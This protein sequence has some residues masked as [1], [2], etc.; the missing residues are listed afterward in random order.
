M[1]NVKELSLTEVVI[2]MSNPR[3]KMDAGKLKDLAESIK[4]QGVIE[5]IVVRDVVFTL[6]EKVKGKGL[7]A[8]V[9]EMSDMK[10]RKYEVVCGARRVEAAKLAGLKEIPAVIMDLDDAQVHEMRLIENLQ[11]EDMNA[12]DEANGFARIV[13]ETKIT[14]ED[15]ASKVGKS[16]GYVAGRLQ[17]LE[18]SKTI[19]SAIASGTI[20]PGHGAVILR[21]TPGVRDKFY[22]HIVKEKLSIR[23]AENAL[24]EFAREL[25]QAP[26]DRKECVKCNFNG[27]QQAGLFDVDTKLEGRC[28]NALCFKKKAEDFIA[29]KVVELKK[30]GRRVLSIKQYYATPNYYSM[31]DIGDNYERRTLGKKYEEKCRECPSLIFVVDERVNAQMPSISEHCP[32]S[33]CYRRLTTSQRPKS[34]TGEDYRKEREKRQAEERVIEAKRRFWK[35]SIIEGASPADIDCIV[36]H[37]LLE[38]VSHYA[39]IRE[40][41]NPLIDKLSDLDCSGKIA[42]KFLALPSK[43]LATVMVHL[44]DI[45]INRSLNL[46]DEDLEYFAAHL[47]KSVAKDF[48]IDEAYLQPKTKAQLLKLAKELGLYRKAEEAT[49][50]AQ[51]KKPE[52]I[53]WIL[54]HDLKGKVPAEIAGKKKKGGK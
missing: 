30:A 53:T 43:E 14:Q 24:A 8:E 52:L 47:K 17:L 46:E 20:T 2:S 18:L 35:K 49:A 16:Q 50:L 13:E 33:S 45:A 23:S 28:L 42:E 10:V 25:S 34:E 11:R 40:G 31:V 39:S 36:A 44:F 41:S 48:V 21:L 4:A 3:Q 7:K 15:L 5:P 27:T 51:M 6:P 38:Y 1:K 9:V 54:G 37:L 29:A 26:F 12:I 32:D 22:G 19:Q